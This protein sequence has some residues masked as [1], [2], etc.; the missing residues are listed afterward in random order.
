MGHLR[1]GH[2][3]SLPSTTGTPDS[4]QGK[5]V[6]CLSMSETMDTKHMPEDLGQTDKQGETEGNK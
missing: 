2:G 4:F 5:R 3:P 1:R 6:R